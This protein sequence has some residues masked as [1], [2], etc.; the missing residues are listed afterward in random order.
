M[1]NI[2]F[3]GTP[4][5][6]ATCLSSLIEDGHGIC[7]V[8]TREDKPRGRGNTMTPTPVKALALEHGISVYTPK[9]LR[10]EEFAAILDEYKPELIV[11]VAYGKILPK[12][13]ID[14]PR[15]GCINLHVS[16]L[17]KYRG[18]APMQ[19]AIMEGESETG[20][21]VMYMDEGL[22]TGDILSVSKF[23]IGPTD[24]FEAIHDRSAL[25]GG[26]LLS[27]TIEKIEKNEIQRI[28]Q[29]D[30]LATYASKVEKED[31]K[32]NFAL[33]AKKLDFIIRG[34]TPIP[35]A[36]A[37]LNGKML[38]INKATPIEKN[39]EIGRVID[40]SDKGEGYFTVACGEGALKITAIIPEGKGKMSAGDFIR[41]RKISLGDILE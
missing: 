28:K 41:G 4:E 36:F 19:R 34:V 37:Y 31:C 21:T 12:S 9:T 26:G 25:I 39:G 16:L 2:M 35:G 18:A 10:D 7:A 23:P 14:Y 30:S 6:A 3:M 11:V 15:Y 40:L 1:K 29:D 24:D 33:S 22:D 5:I 38:K 8:V 13:V 20:V 32:L 17:P 27:E